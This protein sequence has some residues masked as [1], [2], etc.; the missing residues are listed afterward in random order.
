MIYGVLFCII[1]VQC[2]TLLV[3]YPMYTTTKDTKSTKE[4]NSLLKSGRFSN[5][6]VRSSCPL[7][8]SW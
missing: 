3:L 8:A 1:L 4:E 5:P 7:C 6:V 2:L